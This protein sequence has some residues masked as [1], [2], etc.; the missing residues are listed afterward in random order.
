MWIFTIFGWNGDENYDEKVKK[1]RVKNPSVFYSV[2]RLAVIVVDCDAY[3]NFESPKFE[4]V[5]QPT[6][7]IGAERS[8]QARKLSWL[9]GSHSLK[10][11]VLSLF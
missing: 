10:L 11:V 9:L 4:V 5:A 1:W 8:F 7:Q 6:T 3:L 2:S